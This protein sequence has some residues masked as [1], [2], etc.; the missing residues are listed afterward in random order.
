MSGRRILALSGSLRRG[1]YN[2]ALLRAAAEAAPA[3]CAVEVR[4]LADIP[5]YDDDVRTR[6]GFPPP[7]ADLRDAVRAADA[8]LIAT[9]EY[10][11]SFSGVIKNAVDWI[12]RPPDQPFAGRPVAVVSASPGITGGIRAQWALK[13]VLA[14][15]GARVLFRPEL[16]VGDARA[17]FDEAGRLVDAETRTRLA[18]LLE[19]LLALV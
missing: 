4:T 6:E 11:Y 13:P 9:P 17:K 5:L 10:N 7:V 14:A 15:L 18:A 8:L 2:T 1:S 19:A 16:A 12:S 3:G